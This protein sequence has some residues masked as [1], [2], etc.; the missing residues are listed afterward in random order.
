MKTQTYTPGKWKVLKSTEKA[1][2]H[3]VSTT[4]GLV[5]ECWSGSSMRGDAE[6]NARLI[7]AAPELLE[8]LRR[9]CADGQNIDP[10]KYLPTKADW[11]FAKAAIAKAEG[12]S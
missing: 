4:D 1:G 7:A 8:A 6:M 9:L 11:E 5:A 10:A 12:R 3:I 2:Y